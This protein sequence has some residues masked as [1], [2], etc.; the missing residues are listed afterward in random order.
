MNAEWLQGLGA[1][2]GGTVS[3][4]GLLAVALRW[5][6]I[7]AL[8]TDRFAL[9]EAA[10]DGEKRA[11]AAERLAKDYAGSVTAMRVT[12]AEIDR[13]V[14]R[15]EEIEE[16]FKELVGWVA[17]IFD[18][19]VYLEREALKGGVDISARAMPPIPDSLVDHI[20]L[21]N[22]LRSQERTA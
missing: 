7:H 2:F 5:T 12:V 3:F 10:T 17:K 6:R 8:F 21:P 13:R 14:K 16:K 20:D 1:F 9:V 18:Y 11:A 22:E 4:F 15:L 19:I